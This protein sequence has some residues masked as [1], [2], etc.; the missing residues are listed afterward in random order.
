M[1]IRVSKNLPLFFTAELQACS[2]DT[3]ILDDAMEHLFHDERHPFALFCWVMRHELNSNHVFFSFTGLE[4]FTA[5]EMAYRMNDFFPQTIAA[6]KA[7]AEYMQPAKPAMS[8]HAIAKA[9]INAGVTDIS[10]SAPLHSI[11]F[12]SNSSLEFTALEVADQMQSIK[13]NGEEEIPL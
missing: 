5:E 8:A 7:A 9:L 3:K 1:L 12:W 2:C 6:L 13:G 11:Y 4:W 10:G